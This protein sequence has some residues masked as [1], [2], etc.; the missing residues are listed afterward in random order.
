MSV[1]QENVKKFEIVYSGLCRNIKKIY[2]LRPHF[3]TQNILNEYNH[4]L[5]RIGRNFVMSYNFREGLYHLFLIVLKLLDDPRTLETTL[6]SRMVNSYKKKYIKK[7]KKI[8]SNVLFKEVIELTDELYGELMNRVTKLKG[9][10]VPANN[11][12]YGVRTEGI[13]GPLPQAREIGELP[14]STYRFANSPID[15][16]APFARASPVKASPAKTFKSRKSK[17]KSKSVKGTKI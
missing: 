10:F 14:T 6:Y 1:T 11:A 12:N 7:V 2:Q 9:L 17:S 5:E 13:N 3:F 8:L 15:N 4:S 16:K